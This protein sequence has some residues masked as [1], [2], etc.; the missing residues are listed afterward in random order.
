MEPLKKCYSLA[1]LVSHR[2]GFFILPVEFYMAWN[3]PRYIVLEQIFENGYSIRTPA[4]LSIR[5]T[6]G[7]IKR[8]ARLLTLSHVDY[9]VGVFLKI[10]IRY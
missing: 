8:R 4:R 6:L 7:K 5:T 3:T 9:S 10:K 1:V 2:D